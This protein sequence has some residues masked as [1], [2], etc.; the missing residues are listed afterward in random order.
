MCVHLL[1]QSCA[2][3]VLL[4]LASL[5][6]LCGLLYFP[7]PKHSLCSCTCPV[8]SPCCVFG[9]DQSLC[10]VC[11]I[12][13]PVLSTL[14]V[15]KLAS[16]VHSVC[17]CTYPV[18]YTEPFKLL[19]QSCALAVFMSMPSP[20]HTVC[21]IFYTMLCTL[22][23]VISGPVLCTLCVSISGQS[24]ASGVFLYLGI[25]VHL[26]SSHIWSN[27]VHFICFCP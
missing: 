20:V 22:C 10:N 4:Y 5:C 15:L 12:I 1:V 26:T 2:L 9:H 25:P 27:F 17:S 13:Y 16:P 18:S 11:S 7:S 21:Y 14:Y 6:A 24:S 23:V 8:L 19:A 3:S